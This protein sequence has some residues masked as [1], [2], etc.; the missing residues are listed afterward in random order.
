M[1]VSSV[2]AEVLLLGCRPTG[3]VCSDRYHPWAMYYIHVKGPSVYPGRAPTAL[4]KKNRV[5]GGALAA[6]RQRGPSAAAALQRGPDSTGAG[7]CGLAT[8]WQT[9]SRHL[10]ST[11]RCRLRA[12]GFGRPAP[13]CP[14][15][16]TC[17]HALQAPPGHGLKLDLLQVFAPLRCGQLPRLQLLQTG[18][19]WVGPVR[20]PLS[21]PAP[22]HQ[23]PKGPE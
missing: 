22:H 2:I 14:V 5:T 21:G 7:L 10:L 4:V 9:L 1:Q 12:C 11:T 17:I 19:G 6:T 3:A 13:L 15:L 18:P 23:Q 20:G 8:F 16:F